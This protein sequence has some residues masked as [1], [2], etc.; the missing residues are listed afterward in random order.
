MELNTEVQEVTKEDIL[1]R[2]DLTVIST[3]DA[4]KADTLLDSIDKFLSA[5]A[6]A[7]KKDDDTK[8]KLYGEV[9][10]IWADLSDHINNIGFIFNVDDNEYKMLKQYI[11]N[12][13][14]Y[15]HQS[16][17]MGVQLKEDFFKRADIHRK[18]NESILITCNETVLLHHLLENGG[19]V[20][21]GL[22][23]RSYNLRNILTA[24]GNINK[25]FN[26]LDVASKRAGGEINDWVQGLEKDDVESTVKDVT[27]KE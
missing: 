17:F 7:G 4:K 20:V 5:N 23:T 27:V 10:A 25:H 2:N 9:K 22:D 15:D 13:C 1:D 16:V 11:L 14:E 24:I 8:T 19:M 3:E 12:K 18:N 21:K 26:E 6:E